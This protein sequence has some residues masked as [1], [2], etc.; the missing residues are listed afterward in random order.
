MKPYLKLFIA[1]LFSLGLHGQTTHEKLTM[2][3]CEC[4]NDANSLNEVQDS[5]NNC[6][7]QA[8][9]QSIRDSLN[10]ADNMLDVENIQSAAKAIEKLLPDNCAHIR[11]LILADKEKQ[12][13]RLSES[14]KANQH[15][16]SGNQLLQQR[17]YKEARKEFKA[18]LVIDDQFI[19]AWDHLAVSY[20]REEK[21]K[22]AI[23]IYQKS[24]E[25]YPEGH[26]ALLNIAVSYSFIQDYNTS[27]EYYEK[28]KTLYPDNPEGYFGAARIQIIQENYADA[29]DNVFTAHRIYEE[30][31]SDYISDSKK[32]ISILYTLM[33][34]EGLSDL[35]N[36]KAGTYGISI[37]I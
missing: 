29:L 28:L 9:M 25:I 13:Y 1:I 32:L 10:T 7:S 23:K 37:H 3:T 33:E 17:K 5:L 31:N 8:I 6:I 22:K 35:F 19:Y 34:E 36:E 16:D 24:L 18:A 12:H 27:L 21:F 4:L 20:R 26:V 2:A 30:I 14:L 15:Y 11:Q